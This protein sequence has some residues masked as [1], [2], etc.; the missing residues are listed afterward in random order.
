MSEAGWTISDDQ[1]KR[2]NEINEK[3][4]QAQAIL[5]QLAD[6]IKTAFIMLGVDLETE[7]VDLKT[8]EVTKLTT[9]P[10]SIEDG[11]AGSDEVEVVA[12]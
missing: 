3:R 10:E 12:R 8:G 2:I 6:E 4:S 7:Q 9:A 11:Q 5:G 1:L